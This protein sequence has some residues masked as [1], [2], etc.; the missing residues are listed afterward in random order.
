LNRGDRLVYPAAFPDVGL[1]GLPVMLRGLT[2]R[3]ETGICIRDGE[4][5][6]LYRRIGQRP[7]A[8]RKPGDQRTIGARR[9][10]L[11]PAETEQR[12]VGEWPIEADP[13]QRNRGRLARALLQ[14]REAER[15][16]RTVPERA[17]FLGDRGRVADRLEQH[18]ALRRVAGANERNAEVE[19]CESGPRRI[20]V[21][22]P[23]R[24]RR[25][26]VTAERH[27]D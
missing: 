15:K 10:G 25:V 9:V 13:A 7:V 12:P 17:L 22:Y 4:Q 1:Y 19:T 23:K 2:V 11:R 6:L 27:E 24:G 3:G 20:V 18:A 16:V 5:R 26:G 8:Q 14:Q 21:P